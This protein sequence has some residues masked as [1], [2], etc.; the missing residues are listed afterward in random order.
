MDILIALVALSLMLYASHCVHMVWRNRL[1]NSVMPTL[2]DLRGF[3]PAGRR[4]GKR[5]WCA[6]VLGVM[7]LLIDI[8][9]YGSWPCE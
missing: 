2:F 1:P 3:N 7:F 6:L 4:Y 5:F 8:G 9:I